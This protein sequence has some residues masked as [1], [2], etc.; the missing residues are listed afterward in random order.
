MV[1][2]DGFTILV[3]SDDIGYNK[4][5][6]NYWFEIIKFSTEVKTIIF[7]SLKGNN[8]IPTAIV[9]GKNTPT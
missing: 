3:G 8:I 5:V 1:V 2:F 6:L 7:I 4:Y 9:T